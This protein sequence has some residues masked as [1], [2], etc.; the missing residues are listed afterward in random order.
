MTTELR[1]T[2]YIETHGCKLNQA[3]SQVL[4]QRFT[5]AGYRLAEEPGQADVHVV[6]TCTVTHVA[7]SKARH[8]LR[9]AHRRNPGG[10]VVATGC[11]AQ[12]APQQLTQ[13]EG[14][15]LVLGNTQKDVLVDRVSAALGLQEVPCSTG[16]P[17]PIE[18]AASLRT[19]AMVKIQEGCDQV[20]AYC[21]VP[22]VRGRERSIHPDALIAQVRRFVDE[23][24]QE[25]VLTGTQL[26]TYGFDISGVSLAVLISRIL[27]QT[28]MPRLRV[29]SLQPQELNDEL[30]DLWDN[31]RLCPHFH[32][33][34]Q[35]GSAAV[36]K[37]MRRRYSPQQYIEAV[38]SVRRRVPRAAITADVIVG[39]PGET[40]EQFQETYE[41]CR[42]VQFAGLHVFPYSKRPG[43]SAAYLEPR[44]E[45]REKRLRMESVLS[46]A[47]EQAQSYRR[48]LLGTTCGVLWETGRSVAGAKV[49]SGLT[50]NYVRVATLSRRPLHNRI[51]PAVLERQQDELVWAR[52]V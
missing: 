1:P 6:N 51:T 18:A 38:E 22:K 24:F 9:D 33:P 36:L 12:R 39:F 16:A 13:V 37:A 3:D 35:S 45:D 20:C 8:A 41:V 10:L 42:D 25:V 7:D 49:W 11:Y 40:R 46:L 5:Q 44:V 23:G 50:D 4:A 17:E 32:V 2:V 26:G 47:K 29:S 19:R 28:S 21:I 15:G 31:P 30:L 14:V 34:L 27:R 52:V 43:T 48:N